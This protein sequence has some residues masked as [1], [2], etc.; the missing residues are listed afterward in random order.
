MISYLQKVLARLPFDKREEFLSDE[1][2]QVI[3]PAENVKDFNGFHVRFPAP[4][5]SLIYI[6]WNKLREEESRLLIDYGIA[7]EIGHHFAGN[8]DSRL[9][10]KE[11]DDLLR[12]WGF[13]EE[14]DAADHKAAIYQSKGYY[15]GYQWAKG[16]D[17][18]FLWKEYNGFLPLWED[19]NL[20]LKKQREFEE[21][22][23]IHG[24][25]NAKAALRD[26]GETINHPALDIGI[27]HGVM[28]RVR[29]LTPKKGVR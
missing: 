22:L 17:D 19:E 18:E 8:G 3:T 2:L 27:I 4:V 15:I 12:K 21:E 16:Q 25:G 9:I 24:K 26:S 13:D 6:D 28:K 10:E 20:T 1:S 11:A 5:K 23:H 29:E 14:I 7:H